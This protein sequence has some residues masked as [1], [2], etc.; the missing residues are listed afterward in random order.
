[1]SQEAARALGRAASV[2]TAGHP[3]P[4]RVSVNG[5]LPAK[6]SLSGVFQQIRVA[7]CQKLI[8]VDAQ[9][10]GNIS[11]DDRPEEPILGRYIEVFPPTAL[12]QTQRWM[13]SSPSK[14][15]CRAC[16]R[17]TAAGC[18]TCGSSLNCSVDETEGAVPA[19]YCERRAANNHSGTNLQSNCSMCPASVFP[20]P[21]GKAPAAERRPRLA[22]PAD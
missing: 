12:S 7:A 9:I 16:S 11:V 4:S 14:G 5:Q 6:F 15:R 10:G 1:L 20:V 8:Q 22:P 3:V 13:S 21:S 18:V 19:A 2:A 17:A